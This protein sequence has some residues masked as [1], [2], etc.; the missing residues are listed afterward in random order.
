MIKK[1]LPLALLLLFACRRDRV[2]GVDSHPEVPD[3][4]DFGVIA[5]NEVRSIPISIANTGEIEL[6]VSDLRIN[7][8]FD[9]QTPP[10]P[11]PP[12]GASDVLVKFQPVQ[13]G[14]VTG[15]VT[16]QTSSLGSPLLTVA[17]HGIAYTPTLTAA[18]D[19]LDF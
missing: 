15:S 4:I 6:T 14:E 5:V 10:E 7:E 13:P 9:V 18:P 1:I 16:L 3:Q 17:L 8:P 19:R 11:V 12:G 2:V